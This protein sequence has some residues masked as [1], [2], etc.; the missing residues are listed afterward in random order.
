MKT[1]NVSY[2]DYVRMRIHGPDGLK[3]AL[4]LWLWREGFCKAPISWEVGVLREAIGLSFIGPIQWAV[5]SISSV[6]KL[7]GRNGD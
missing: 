4:W 7:E 3:E 1:A 5:D 6:L 2:E